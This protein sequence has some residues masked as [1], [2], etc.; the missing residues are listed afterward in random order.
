MYKKI[1]A[2]LKLTSSPFLMMV[3]ASLLGS[4]LERQVMGRKKLFYK[5]F[6]LPLLYVSLEDLI[7]KEVTMIRLQRT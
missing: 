3:G 7:I 4:D 6:K 5:C 1:I 2:L